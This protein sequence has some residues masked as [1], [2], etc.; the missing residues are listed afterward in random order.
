[1]F[2]ISTISSCGSSISNAKLSC[3]CMIGSSS[4][5]ITVVKGSSISS[6]TGICFSATGSTFFNSIIIGSLISS[7]EVY[8]GGTIIFSFLSSTTAIAGTSISS[9]ESGSASVVSGFGLRRNIFAK[10]LKS[11][12]VNM[13]M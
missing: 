5:A 11:I 7:F 6:V 3:S 13:I 2:S 9:S 12:L 1:M 8:T 4:P 10:K